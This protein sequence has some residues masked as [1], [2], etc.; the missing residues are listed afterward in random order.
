MK[1]SCKTRILTKLYS[2]EKEWVML[3]YTVIQI[4]HLYRFL[5]QLTEYTWFG[6]CLLYSYYDYGLPRTLPI[7]NLVHLVI[8]S[9]DFSYSKLLTSKLLLLC[10]PRFIN[11]KN[12]SK[13]KTKHSVD[14]IAYL[15]L[16]QLQ[17]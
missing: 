13:L 2:Q 6:Y 15:E 12:P 3:G 9:T 8:L 4:S 7:C 1:Y 14:L 5:V 11:T 10:T 16:R 17:I